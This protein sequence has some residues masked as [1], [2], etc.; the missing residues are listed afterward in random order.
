V[1]DLVDVL[2]RARTLGVLGPGPVEAHIAHADGFVRAVA[3]RLGPVLDLGSG[4][5]VPGLVVACA[6]PDLEVAL[7]DSQARRVALLEEA[8]DALGL[9]ARVRVLHGRAEHL[10][11]DPDL[12]SGFDVVT[13]RSFGPPAVVAECGAGFLGR[14]GR[15]VVS[16]PPDGPDRWPADELALLGLRTTPCATPGVAVLEQFA[17][18]PERYP[19]RNGQPAKR[20]LFTATVG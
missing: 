20:P 6:R 13:A 7:L 5:G 11:R 8:V 16:E 3:D 12:R 18:C 17:P 15:L 2:E 10:A 1:T 19:R 14:G 9:G 4:A